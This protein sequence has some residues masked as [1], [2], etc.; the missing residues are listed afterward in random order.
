[1]K[2]EFHK[3]KVSE[4]RSTGRYSSTL[5]LKVRKS[6][7]QREERIWEEHGKKV[8]RISGRREIDGEVRLSDDPR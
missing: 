5:E 8:R 4:K 6:V 2:R 1:M 3:G 7:S